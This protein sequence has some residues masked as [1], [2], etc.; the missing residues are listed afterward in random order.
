MFPRLITSLVAAVLAGASLLVAPTAAGAEV[1]REQVLVRTQDGD[2]GAIARDVASRH[3]GNVTHVFRHAVTGFAMELPSPA[4][5]ALRSDPR[6]ATVEPDHPVELY[7]VPT[8]VAR[9]AITENAVADIDGTD[10]RVDVDIAV[11]DSGIDSTHPDL[12]VFRGA[13]C[14][15][16]TCVELSDPVDVNGHGTHVAGTAA[17]IDNGIGVVGAAPGARLWSVQILDV[18][19]KADLSAVLAG[20]DWI[21]SHADRIEVA[22]ASLGCACSSATLD[23]A[24]SEVAEAGV[25]LVA[26]A[27]N[28]GQDIEGHALTA[29]PDVITVSAMADLDGE[30]GAE[31]SSTC[32]GESDDTFASF[33]SY[34]D[35][36]DLAAPGV[37]IVSTWP[38]E[39]LARSSGTSMAAPHV[40]GAAALYIVQESVSRNSRRPATVRNGLVA[41][42][43]VSQTSACGFTDGV[44]G[45]PLLYLA[46][47]GADASSN[48][49]PTVAIDEPADGTRVESGTSLTFAGAAADSEDGDLS[50]SIS[51][52]SDLDGTLGTGS[53]IS[54]VLS[55]GSHVV[56][57]KVR[58]SAGARDTDS[59]TVRVDPE[60]TIGRLAGADRIG[61]SVEISREAFADGATAAVVAFAG[62][63]PDALA[64]TPLASSVDGPVLLNHRDQ[65]H[66]DVATELDRLGVETAYVMGGTAVQTSEVERALQDR[67]M[68]T[69]RVSGAD[70][71]ATASDAA[72]TAAVT[73]QEAGQD[74]ASNAVL[75]LGTDFPDALSGGA[76]AAARR[77]PLLLTARDQLPDATASALRDLGASSVTVIGGAAAVSDAVIQQ[78][79]D[80][81]FTTDRL[82]GATRFETAVDAA[83]ATVAAGGN[84]RSV[85]LASGRSFPDAL[86]GAPAV[87]SRG[88][89]LLLSER[90]HL[91]DPTSDALRA[92][93][94]NWVRLAGG[95]SVL[96]DTVLEQTSSATGISP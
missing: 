84:H 41:E 13:N 58:D 59:I 92:A 69:V 93:D 38:A 39:R 35:E 1:A 12:N 9:T 3:G 34:G 90:D 32:D 75:A 21:R 63:F 65:L 54:A 64:A 61:T 81:G 29:H 33:S 44:S 4:V 79:R 51:W 40:A 10:E 76:L 25:V 72:R 24:V 62:D 46:S 11:L 16:G 56:T 52:S 45:E 70:R 6:V 74:V 27:G 36:V 85:V 95:T 5:A 91:P 71:F 96:T 94:V 66:P 87:A 67:G 60:P 78:L 47:C 82:A 23:A 26:A 57:A 17:A 31:T 53:E 83:D 22:N 2:P 49:A 7:E 42:W 28:A 20:L 55:E 88:G 18:N 80:A 43:S 68:Q 86:A 50:A 48:G 77:A 30:P 89:V 15:T 19:G 37:C 73:W 8:G 14:S